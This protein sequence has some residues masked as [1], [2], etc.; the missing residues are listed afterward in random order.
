MVGVR[1]KEIKVEVEDSMYLIIWI[2]AIDES[3]EPAKSFMRKFRLPSMIDIGGI[4][5][6]YE[7]GVITV[8][9]PRSFR[10][11]EFYINLTDASIMVKVAAQAA[12]VETWCHALVACAGFGAVYVQKKCHNLLVP[13]VSKERFNILHLFLLQYLSS[14]ILHMNRGLFDLDYDCNSLL[15][16]N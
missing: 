6:G 8:A 13:L 5:V 16:R 7:D 14:N 10:R 15:S 11:R 9:L 3:S 12:W 2:E 4:S 1:K